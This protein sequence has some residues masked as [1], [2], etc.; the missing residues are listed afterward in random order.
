MNSSPVNGLMSFKGD[1]RHSSG[2][3]RIALAV[4]LNDAIVG[5]VV[6][7][8]ATGARTGPAVAAFLHMLSWHDTHS[9]AR[10]NAAPISRRFVESVKHLVGRALAD[11]A[12]RLSTS[13]A[14]A[15]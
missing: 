6:G 9:V 10:Y 13:M 12:L 3:D 8:L 5:A 11:I 2:Q 4:V 14:R 1:S 7:A 15:G